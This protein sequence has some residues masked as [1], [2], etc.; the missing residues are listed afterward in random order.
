MGGR[1]VMENQENFSTQ[2]ALGVE[3]KPVSTVTPDIPKQLSETVDVAKAQLKVTA[4]KAVEST[5]KGINRFTMY[6]REKETHEM[7]QDLGQVIRKHPGKSMA[8]GLALGFL[9][10]KILR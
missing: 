9:V 4:N 5:S 10:G 6:I 3:T 1:I 7:L 8:M 2:Q